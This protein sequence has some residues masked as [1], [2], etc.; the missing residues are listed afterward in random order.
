MG[1]PKF[2]ID[3]LGHKVVLDDD[4]S[5][6]A[7]EGHGNLVGFGVIE[8]TVQDPDEIY[9]SSRSMT[10]IVYVRYN[11]VET[12][13]AKLIVEAVAETSISPY[14]VIT[15]YVTNKAHGIEGE[16]LYVRG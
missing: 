3:P 4:A 6:H 5:T 16:P 15:A 8:D 14:R 13:A 2:L 9:R 12:K 7:A 10:R 1:E 11:L